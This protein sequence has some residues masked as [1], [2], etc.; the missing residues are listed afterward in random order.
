MPTARRLYAGHG[1]P[2]AEEQFRSQAEQAHRLLTYGF[3]RRDL[4]AVARHLPSG[5]WWLTA[6]V[7]DAADYQLEPGQQEVANQSVEVSTVALDLRA[8]ATRYPRR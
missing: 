3:D 4:G 5:G 7:I 8:R 2:V 6:R 1:D